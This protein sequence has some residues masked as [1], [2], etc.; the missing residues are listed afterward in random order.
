MFRCNNENCVEIREITAHHDVIAL[1]YGFSVGNGGAD[2]LNKGDG[3]MVDIEEFFDRF[4]D[5]SMNPIE[6]SILFA[7]TE[8][9]EARIDGSLQNFAVLLN[10]CE[11]KGAFDEEDARIFVVKDLGRVYNI[12][13]CGWL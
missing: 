1:L 10:S 4:A 12:G 9:R 13:I 2:L 6:I 3:Y 5:R 11:R 7:T 8:S